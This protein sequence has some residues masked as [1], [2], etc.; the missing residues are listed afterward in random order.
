MFTVTIFVHTKKIGNLRTNVMWSANS[1]GIFLLLEL[2][3]RLG[4]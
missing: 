1:F 4:F 2:C 3:L